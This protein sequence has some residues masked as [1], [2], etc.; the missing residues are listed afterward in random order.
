[1]GRI[2][3][4]LSGGAISVMLA[5]HYGKELNGQWSVALVYGMLVA[6][7]VEGGLG[8]L[9]MRD[10]SRDPVAAGRAVGLVLKGRLVVGA[11][12]VPLALGSA[13]LLNPEPA[14]W[15]LI[16]LCVAMRYAEGLQQSFH[17]LLVALGH[18]RLTNVAE[19]IRRLV[20]V[21]AVGVIVLLDGSLLWQAAALLVT[22]VATSTLWLRATR[23]IT[24]LD[25]SGSLRSAWR[26]AMW[27][28]ISGVLFWINGEFNQLILSRVAGDAAAGL[29][30]A[31]YRVTA[32]GQIVPQV[33]SFNIVPRLFRSSKDPS[34]SLRQLGTTALLMGGLGSAV[35]AGMYC[36]G[37]AA[38]QLLYGAAYQDSAA[39]FK[40]QGLYLMGLFMRTPPSWFM[41]T[42][43]RV[44]RMALYLGI[45]CVTNLVV[46]STLI[47]SDG[48]LGGPIGAAVGAASSE[49]VMLALT[50]SSALRHVSPK[51]GGALLLGL[52]PGLLTLAFHGA[53]DRFLPWYLAA[54]TIGALVVGALYW[55]ALRIRAGWNPLGL[56]GP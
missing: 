31:A 26:D 55:T 7:A 46:S 36:Y 42:S 13:W 56:L 20:Q 44:P 34:E 52:L 48:P 10:V 15:F 6:T 9:L 37:D 19:V 21:A 4:T 16:V 38:I 41:S 40:V 5:R 29:Y 3:I 35:A 23:R 11:V 51:I 30:G 54:G 2:S 53:L 28:W 18:Y 8:T 27:F 12:V 50:L 43:D 24:T 33:L 45:G 49:M 14:R 25:F 47:P 17:S 22:V 39:I 1:L 32:I